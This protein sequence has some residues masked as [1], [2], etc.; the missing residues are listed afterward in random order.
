MDSCQGVGEGAEELVAH[1]PGLSGEQ[2]TRNP[3]I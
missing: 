3:V 2:I 1:K